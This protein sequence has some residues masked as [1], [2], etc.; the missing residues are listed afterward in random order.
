MQVTEYLKKMSL[1]LEDLATQMDSLQ[2]QGQNDIVSKIIEIHDKNGN[3]CIDEVEYY[4][5]NFEE[6]R[7]DFEFKFKYKLHCFQAFCLFE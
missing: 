5:H 6:Q 4:S 1:H 2:L 7:Q 3:G